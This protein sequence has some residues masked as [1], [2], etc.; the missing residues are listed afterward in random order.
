MGARNVGS[1]GFAKPIS[2]VSGT[3]YPIW[4]QTTVSVI[5]TSYVAGGGTAKIYLSPYLSD[6]DTT[7]VAWVDYATIGAVGKV[8]IAGA[9]ARIKLVLTVACT[10]EA[11]LCTNKE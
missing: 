5:V 10:C 11:V 7:G 4:S 1:V 8:D 2:M 9:V 3:A 6:S